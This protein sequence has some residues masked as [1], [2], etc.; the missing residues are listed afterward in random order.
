MVGIADAHI[1]PHLVTAMHREAD[2]VPAIVDRP[3]HRLTNLVGRV[4]R[5][6]KA[7]GVIVFVDGSQQAQVALLNEIEQV[8]HYTL[9][10]MSIYFLA[11]TISNM[12]CI[13]AF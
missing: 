6:L 7:A 11:L 1:L 13:L 2:F 5:E 9:S 8:F 12:V 3:C 4:G 10:T